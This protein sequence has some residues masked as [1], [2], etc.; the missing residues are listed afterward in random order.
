M[1]FTELGPRTPEDVKRLQIEHGEFFGV[2][3][4]CGAA[5]HVDRLVEFDFGLNPVEV[6]DRCIEIWDLN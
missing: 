5:G 1:S 6:C 3:A 4:L 2:C